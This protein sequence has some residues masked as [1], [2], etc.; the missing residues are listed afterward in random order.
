MRAGPGGPLIE[1]LLRRALELCGSNPAAC[2]AL[3]KQAYD[4]LSREDLIAALNAGEEEE[5]YAWDDP[6]CFPP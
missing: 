6:G 5:P 2:M 1:E 3:V 4:E